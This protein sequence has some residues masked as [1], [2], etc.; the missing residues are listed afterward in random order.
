MFTRWRT[1]SA[2]Q[3]LRL[4]NVRHVIYSQSFGKVWADWKIWNVDK[5]TTYFKNNPFLS[6]EALTVQVTQRVDV[7]NNSVNHSASRGN[8]CKSLKFTKYKLAV[9]NVYNW[10]PKSKRPDTWKKSTRKRQKR[11]STKIL[12]G[13]FLK[14]DNTS[15]LTWNRMTA[16]MLVKIEWMILTQRNID[17][18]SV[19]SLKRTHR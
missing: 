19:K 6:F 4:S 13:E 14:T 12:V 3:N 11:L 8:V 18:F 10:R 17:S 2:N 5:G 15:D 9:W 16:W 7:L 1:P